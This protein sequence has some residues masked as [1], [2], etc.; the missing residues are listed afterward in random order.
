[1]PKKQGEFELY[2][3]NVIEPMLLRA[4]WLAEKFAGKIVA[5]GRVSS[6]PYKA[7]PGIDSAHC[8]S[9]IFA[10]ISDITLLERPVDIAEFSHFQQIARGVTITPV[11][12]RSFEKL[13][14]VL[15]AGNDLPRYVDSAI[16]VPDFCRNVSRHNWMTLADKHRRSFTLE[17]E[18]RSCYLDFLLDDLSESSVWRECRFT[19]KTGFGVADYVIEL[20]GNRGEGS[21][22]SARKRAAGTKQRVNRALSE[23]QARWSR[24]PTDSLAWH[25]RRRAPF[26]ID[27]D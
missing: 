22:A 4:H 9:P 16:P 27:H 1:M 7:K 12:G 3:R 21:R 26:L 23:H 25:H 2:Q 14:S 11:L 8:K 5:V 19:K 13:R 24:K 6:L 17:E 18:F 10:D 15:G 20:G